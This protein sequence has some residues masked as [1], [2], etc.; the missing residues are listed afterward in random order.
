MINSSPAKNFQSDYKAPNLE[1]NMVNILLPNYLPKLDEKI[2]VHNFHKVLLEY[3]LETN[4]TMRAVSKIIGLHEVTY[5]SYLSGKN[6]PDFK[7]LKKLSNVYGVDLLQVAFEQNHEFFMGKKV[8]K[9]PRELTID[10]AYYIG[11][12]QG[13]GY[14]ESD[15][16]SYGFADEYLS[17]IEQMN[18]LTKNI[19]N[20]EGHIY[21][22]VSK[23]ATKPCY[24]LVIN[25]F[26]IN[27]FIHEFFG[28]IRGKKIQLRIPKIMY[29]NKQI[30]AS[31][32]SGLYDADGTI[33]KQPQ[34]AKQLFVDVTMK[35]KIFMEEIKEV[36][37]SFGI[38]SLKLYE[39]RSHS[40]VGSWDSPSWEIRIRRHGEILNF[41]REIGFHHPDKSR[42]AKEVISMLT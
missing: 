29:S 10:L 38:S 31:Y 3:H 36:L 14:L 15:K 35:D 40:G 24:N 13:D 12:L 2:K 19:F 20:A 28:I 6:R 26:V 21:A 7:M 39:R 42:R 16:K 34:K 25:S 18:V 11:Y 33:P 30:L 32:I 4:L 37:N 5:R 1:S 22:V 17:Q 41:L 23:I 8:I 9:L 27:S